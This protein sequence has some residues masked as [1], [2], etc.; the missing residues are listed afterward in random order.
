MFYFKQQK[1]EGLTIR[2]LLTSDWHLRTSNPENRTDPSF[3]ETQLGKIEQILNIAVENKCKHILQAGDFTDSPRPSFSLIED[4]VSLFKKYNI[5]ERIELLHVFGQHDTY[6]RT[7]E[8]TATKLFNFLGYIK[9]VS[10]LMRLTEDIHLYGAS[11]GE[12]IPKIEDMDAFNILL[13][14][15]TITDKPLWVG[16]DD[17]LQSDKLFKNNPYDIIHCGDN[18]HPV[19]YKNKN[20]VIVGCGSIVRKTISESDL[21]PHVL[22]ITI[23]DNDLAYTLK[24]I[25]LKYEP[26]DKVFKPEALSREVNVENAKMI[27]FIESIKSNSISKNLDFKKN[28]ENLLI[29][30]EQPIKDIIMEELNER[31][32]ENDR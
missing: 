25:E 27:T 20:Q 26:A 15:K 1:L 13:I 28:L 2:I 11:W 7:K 8:R 31:I 6:F 4:Y 14:H 18:H 3:F 24:K 16:H 32:K 23:N 21:T 5:G 30:I 19:F 12:E 10:G 29:S 17:F 22:L 9:E